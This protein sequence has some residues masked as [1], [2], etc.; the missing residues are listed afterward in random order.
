MSSGVGVVFWRV[1]RLII[2]GKLTQGDTNNF[3]IRKNFLRNAG[4][5]ILD[6]T[7]GQFNI[8]IVTGQRYDVWKSPAKGYV[9]NIFSAFAI[10][11]PF[12]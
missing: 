3:N 10:H 11:K 12:P 8:L 9:S 6:M 7:F 2:V 1:M 5:A 4:A